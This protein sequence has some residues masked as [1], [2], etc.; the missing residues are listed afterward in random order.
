MS[1][2][3]EQTQMTYWQHWRFAMCYARCCMVCAVRLFLHAWMPQL[4]Q[5]AGRDLVCRMRGDFECQ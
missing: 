1:D 3:L 2:H 4:H 5:T